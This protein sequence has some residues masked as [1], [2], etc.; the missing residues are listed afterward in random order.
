MT[1]PPDIIGSLSRAPILRRP[2]WRRGLF[3][4]AIVIC[5]LLT[6]FPERYR[7]AVTMTPTDPQS[8]GLGSTLGQ[9][10]AL[11]TAFGNQAAVEVSL[12]V[13][14]S[15]FVRSSVIR[16]V[17]LVERL[18]LKD[19]VAASRWLNRKVDIRT[20]RGGIL[21]IE[22][23]S[24]DQAFGRAIVTAFENAT[25]NKLA[26]IARRQTNYK[27]NVLE[28]LVRDASRR[29]TIAESRYNRF[30]LGAGFA[31]PRF[32]FGAIA[33][34]VPT[35]QAAIRSKQVELNA[36]R[37]FNTDNTVPVQ[38]IRAELAQLNR[39][40]TE[41]QARNPEGQ[42][43]TGQVV[44]QSTELRELE[45]EYNIALSLYD[46]YRRYLEGTAVEDLTSTATVRILEAPFIDTARQYN[47]V[48]AALGILLLLLALG[49]EFYRLR[50]PVGDARWMHA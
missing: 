4:V 34:R 14:R 10:G 37:Q 20:M 18:D 39:Q 2:S 32:S 30:R 22:T 46:G 21:Q 40:L 36:A 12:K 49:I 33:V 48:A 19:E 26:E 1:P 7:A 6:F 23:F 50:P 9:L 38:Q 11:N 3:A 29:V 41:S 27:R 47:F 28:Q 16:Q 24:R 13:A 45:R 31:D 42:E 44:R 25:R 15:V 8:L 43:S 5:L 17:R 35:L